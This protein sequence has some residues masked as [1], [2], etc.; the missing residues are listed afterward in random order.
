MAITEQRTQEDTK[1]VD[2]IG[3]KQKVK[4]LENVY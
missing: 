1:K 3:C 4:K 2:K